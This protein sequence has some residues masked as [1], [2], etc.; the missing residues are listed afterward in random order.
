MSR[1]SNVPPAFHSIKSLPSEFKLGNNP[2][3][4]VV[5]KHG[6]HRLRSTDQIA[7]NASQNGASVGEVSKGVHNRAG[8]MDLCD[9]E[10]PYGGSD[11]SFEDRPVSADEELVSVSK[12]L[13]SNSTSSR[14]SRWSDTT[15]YASKKVTLASD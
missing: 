14:E 15:P 12:P 2:N 8:D 10:S 6:N 11:R 7:S 9:E 1:T 5:G 3:P 4:G 13:P